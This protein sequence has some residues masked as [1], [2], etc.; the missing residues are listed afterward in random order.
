MYFLFSVDTF[1]ARLVEDICSLSS[2]IMVIFGLSVHV[3]D[4]FHCE[5]FVSDY[6]T[7]RLPLSFSVHSF[8]RERVEWQFSSRRT[9]TNWAPEL[10]GRLY[11]LLWCRSSYADLRIHHR[12]KHP[13][14]RLCSKC[15]LGFSPP[16]KEK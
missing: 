6:Y 14:I 2:F 10:D 3:E 8:L 9:Y 13:P 15:W 12:F 16:V 1:P 4:G 7:S 5:I 11:A